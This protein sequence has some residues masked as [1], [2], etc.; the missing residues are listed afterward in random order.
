MI[1]CFF[2]HNMDLDLFISVCFVLQPLSNIERKHY[3]CFSFNVGGIGSNNRRTRHN[4]ACSHCGG[5]ASPSLQGYLLCR[6]KI[7][8]MGAKI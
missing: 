1:V 6:A 3:S 2:P 8:I 5:W 7:A 4:P